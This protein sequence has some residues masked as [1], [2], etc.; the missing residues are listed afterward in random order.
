MEQSKEE[1]PTLFMVSAS[2][3]SIFP[4]FDSKYTKA[5]NGGATPVSIIG[6]ESIDPEEEL[7]LGIAKALAGELI[8]L[9][10]ERVFA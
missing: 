6:E 2:V 8:E 4:N 7:Q 5:I 3:L 10:E 9:K 1:E